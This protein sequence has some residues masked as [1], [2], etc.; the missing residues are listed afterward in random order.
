MSTQ[1]LNLCLTWWV[2][3]QKVGLSWGWQVEYMPYQT[4]IRLEMLT[5]APKYQ[6]A[7]LS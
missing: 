2:E 6:V 4:Q 3:V 5:Q 7:E 1:I